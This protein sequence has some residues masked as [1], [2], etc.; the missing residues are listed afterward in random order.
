MSWVASA[1]AIIVA[2]IAL[3]VLFLRRT[4]PAEKQVVRFTVGPLEQGSFTL[5][6]TNRYIAVS[7]DGSKLA[8]IT[9]VGSRGQQ[10]WIRALDSPSAQALPG[11]ENATFP[12]W[13]PDGRFIG[14]SSGG[15]LKKVALSGGPMETLAEVGPTPGT[16]SRD[17]V[18]L[19][20]ANDNRLDRVSEAGGSAS[21]VTS[22]DSS[23]SEDLI[24]GAQFLPDGKHFIYFAESSKPENSA[25][26]ASSLDS[27]EKKLILKASSNRV[28][29]SPGY[30]LFNRQGTLMAQ[31][32][33]ADRLELTGDAVPIVEGVEFNPFGSLAFFSASNNGVLAYRRGGGFVPLLLVWVGRNGVEQP[34]PAPPHN[35]TYPRISPDG[36]RIAA[37]IEEGEGQIW[38]YDISR[39]V[40][41]RLT[42]GGPSNVDP[43]WTPDG[44][45]VTFKGKGNRLFW[46]SADGGGNA[47]EMTADKLARNNVPSSWSQDGQDLVFLEDENSRSVW[48]LHLKDRTPHV[49]MQDPAY[50]SAP[51]F[52]PDGHWVAYAS[53]ESGRNEIYVR[54]YPGPGGKWQISTEG[55]TEPLW[56]PKGHELFYRSG[57]KMMAVDYTA[58]TSFSA[59][60]PRMLFQGTYTITPR[61][62]TDYDVSPDG[63]RFLMLKPS[64]EQTP[65]QI[66]VVLN[67]PE[68]LKQ[69]VPTGKK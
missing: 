33:D 44:K 45:R 42:F 5:G 59:G 24:E 53:N 52:S 65:G 48:I 13:S 69:K 8:F 50:D 36:K 9:S 63:Q 1:A 28:Y 60:K 41:S 29:V 31:P 62:A 38:L 18:I 56:N 40:L 2:V 3:A 32:F 30:L 16:W 11:T 21:P 68:E 19:F 64:A 25:I 47:E 49:F 55:G 20:T 26:F 51:C 7:P 61:S 66:N 57:Q 22:L 39:D 54:P 27:K 4:P 15:K 6:N 23:R 34:V 58:Q 10:L 43:I 14:F 46:Q 17:G 37:G 67:W 12:F 35:Y